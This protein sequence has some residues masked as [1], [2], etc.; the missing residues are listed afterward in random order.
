M[1]VVS[2][3]S[4]VFTSYK[5]ISCKK[6]KEEFKN[7]LANEFYFF[8][9]TKPVRVLVCKNPDNTYEAILADFEEIKGYGDTEIEAESELVNDLY[10]AWLLSQEP[11]ENLHDSALKLKEFL[12]EIVKEVKEF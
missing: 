12:K 4:S 6:V 7:F 2:L 3:D 5:P 11:D 9:F 10:G 8:Y 1:Q